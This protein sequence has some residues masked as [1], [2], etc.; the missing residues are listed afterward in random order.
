M[1]DMLDVS[2]DPAAGRARRP[3]RGYSDIDG[4]FVKPAQP[5]QT[6]RRPEF[7]MPLETGPPID[8]QLFASTPAA[9]C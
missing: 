5:G 4:T 2:F 6:L 9:P 3:L 7:L 1:N 8:R